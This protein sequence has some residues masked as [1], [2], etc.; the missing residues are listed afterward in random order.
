MTPVSNVDRLAQL[1]RARLL[2]HAKTGRRPATS[3]PT[4]T[5]TGRASAR[6][7]G[8]PPP[9]L[10][11]DPEQRPARR[12]FIALLLA[13][14][15]GEKLL[16]QAQFEQVVIRVE[17]AIAADPEALGMMQELMRALAQR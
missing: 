5:W 16:N 3:A 10:V 9:D 4:R 6:T 12:D 1:I 8:A 17:E 11:G 13:R 7:D 14:E 2:E 15:L